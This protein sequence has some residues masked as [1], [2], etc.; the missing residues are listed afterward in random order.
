[1]LIH[2]QTYYEIV[3]F[4]HIHSKHFDVD[5]TIEG[6][7]Q[8]AKG[9]SDVQTGFIERVIE[10]GETALDLHPPLMQ[11]Q[12]LASETDF[13]TGAATPALTFVQSLAEDL[14][15]NIDS[16]AKS[17]GLDAS[18]L[19]NKEEFSRLASK[20]I[21][22]GFAEFKGNLNE[23]EVELAVD[24]LLNWY[25]AVEATKTSLRPAE[26][27]VTLTSRLITSVTRIQNTSR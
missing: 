5:T 26:L 13:S 2:D 4:I 25:Q 24:E 15:V 9:L 20:V 18:N 22:K 6:D 7:K 21:I 1:M 11:L 16:V 3:D 8:F 23:K 14:G 10:K 19:S 27:F 12:R 17:I